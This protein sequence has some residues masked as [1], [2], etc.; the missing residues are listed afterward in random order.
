MINI[1]E[2]EFGIDDIVLANSILNEVDNQKRQANETL[3]KC[4]RRQE[5]ILHEIEF[6][7]G[8]RREMATLAKELHDI[9]AQR[10]KAKELLELLEPVDNWVSQNRNAVMKLCQAVGRMKSISRQQTERVYTVRSGNGD[11]VIEHVG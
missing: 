10:R 5:D 9:R 7:G 1:P 11:E 4:N 2:H 8:G 6:S 3:L